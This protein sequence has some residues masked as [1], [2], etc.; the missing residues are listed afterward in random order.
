MRLVLITAA[1]ALLAPSAVRATDPVPGVN[2]GLGQNPGGI[3]VASG[4]TD[5]SGKIVFAGVPG[6]TYTVIVEDRTKLPGPVVITMSS[7]GAATVVSA[8]MAP[9]PASQGAGRGKTSSRGYGG[10]KGGDALALVLG[11]PGGPPTSRG[12][13]PGQQ[14]SAPQQSVP[15]TVIVTLDK[16]VVVSPVG[17]APS[18]P[19]SPAPKR[20]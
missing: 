7:P 11:T 4:T 15:I 2:V 13:L 8:P 5:A 10:A 3:I 18:A 19:A 14:R 16:P 6:A 17:K 9:L 1:F 20:N 12:T